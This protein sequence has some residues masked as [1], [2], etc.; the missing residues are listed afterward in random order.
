MKAKKSKRLLVEIEWHDPASDWPWFWWIGE[1]GEFVELQGADYPDG[2]TKHEGDT[3][4]AHRL[5]IKTM[6]TA[7]NG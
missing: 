5:Q 4:W 3:F 2:S 1:R 7:K 6:R